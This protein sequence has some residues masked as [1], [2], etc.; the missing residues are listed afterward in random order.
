MS[1]PAR[2]QALAWA[3][4]EE[5]LARLRTKAETI[6]DLRAQR[7]IDPRNGRSAGDIEVNQRIRAERFDQ[8]DIDRNTV[9]RIH[10]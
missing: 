7:R 4:E 1:E 2:Q 8:P 9:G 10:H 6:A 5:E 3:G